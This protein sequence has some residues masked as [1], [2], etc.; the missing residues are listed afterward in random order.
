[1]IRLLLLLRCGM[2]TPGCVQMKM[3]TFYGPMAV[4]LAPATGWLV[5]LA[6]LALRAARERLTK[7]RVD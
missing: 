7:A 4:L 3:V 2:T 6:A 5:P 1:M